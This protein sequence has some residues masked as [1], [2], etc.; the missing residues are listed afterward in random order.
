LQE[1][2]FMQS[3]IIRSPLT[4]IHALLSLIHFDELTDDNRVYFELI[5][6]AAGQLDDVIKEIVDKA[7]A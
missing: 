3:H 4:N 2:N 7:S 6:K 5:K 1:I